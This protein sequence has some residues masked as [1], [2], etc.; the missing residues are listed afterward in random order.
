[1]DLIIDIGNT[2]AKAALFEGARL[3][4]RAAFELPDTAGLAALIHGAPIAR[5]AIGSVAHE[6]EGL[7]GWL[8]ERFPLTRITSMSPSPIRSAYTSGATLGVDRLANAVAAAHMFPGRAALAIDLG[9]CIT[10]DLVNAQ[11]VYLGGAITPGSRMRA[12]AMHAYSARLPLVEAALDAPAF[13][14]S[15]KSSLQA[16]I[17]HGVLGELEHFIAAARTMDPDTAVVLTGGDAPTHARAL[18]SGIF[19]HPFLTLEGFRLILHHGHGPDPAAA[20]P[21]AGAAG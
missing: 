17:H 9:T 4:R 16:G 2:R 11:R 13:G 19:A 18:K 5:A 1:V 12:Q 10:C 3:L 8:G 15:T 6:A 7:A 14:D 21:S 20:G